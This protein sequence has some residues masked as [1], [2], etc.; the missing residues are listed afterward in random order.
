MTED[1]ASSL[2]GELCRK[3]IKQTSS[4]SQ[5]ATNRVQTVRQDFGTEAGPGADTAPGAGTAWE[6]AFF[7]PSVCW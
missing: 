7:P 4:C 1:Q 2:R 5:K 6:S 3:S